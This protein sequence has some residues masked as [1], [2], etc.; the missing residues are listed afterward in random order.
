MSAQIITA[1]RL[2]AEMLDG[3]ADA[4]ESSPVRSASSRP[5]EN[6]PSLRWLASE[7]RAVADAAER[8]GAAYG[9]PG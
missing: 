5:E 2:R 9:E 6:V 8:S 7:F 3:R 1:L 4:I